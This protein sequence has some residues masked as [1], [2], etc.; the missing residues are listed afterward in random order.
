ME[1]HKATKLIHLWESVA[2]AEDLMTYCTCYVGITVL[3]VWFALME[4][5]GEWTRDGTR[6]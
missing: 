1:Y 5:C 6:L 2:V 3:S 4:F